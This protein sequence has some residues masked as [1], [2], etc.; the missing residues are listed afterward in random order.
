MKYVLV[1]LL[2]L[3]VASLFSGLYFMYRDK[4]ETKRT[5]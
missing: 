3:I 1:L 2:L 4:G 5:V